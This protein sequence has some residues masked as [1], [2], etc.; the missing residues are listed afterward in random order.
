MA[1]N[2]SEK[3]VKQIGKKQKK[4]AQEIVTKFKQAHDL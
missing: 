1:R 4:N 3:N 2:N